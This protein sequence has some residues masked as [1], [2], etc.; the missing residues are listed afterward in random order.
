MSRSPPDSC[1][2]AKRLTVT[3]QRAHA[4]VGPCCSTLA[5][6]P[7]LV[8]A[9]GRKKPMVQPIFSGERAL[10][11]HALLQWLVLPFPHRSHYSGADMAGR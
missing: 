4:P 3:H 11:C 7:E 2:M 9:P 1:H 8:R 5:M 6:L 10:D